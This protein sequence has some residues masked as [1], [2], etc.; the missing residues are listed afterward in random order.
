[1]TITKIC[2]LFDGQFL[3]QFA[4]KLVFF[5]IIFLLFRLLQTK[6][7]IFVMRH[8]KLCCK[9][10]K[11]WQTKFFFRCFRLPIQSYCWA[12]FFFFGSL[13]M[14]VCMPPSFIF[15]IVYPLLLLL[16]TRARAHALCH[17]FS[18]HGIVARV[19]HRDFQLA[20]LSLLLHSQLSQFS[21][22]IMDNI[23]FKMKYAN[24]IYC[25]IFEF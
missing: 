19:Y 17:T 21:G 18:V 12:F 3:G 25:F 11:E 16:A 2:Q 9:Q 13:R 5:I 22:E 8:L 23:S 10:C 7:E 6:W 14:P 4:L 20:W 1:M 15:I 24:A